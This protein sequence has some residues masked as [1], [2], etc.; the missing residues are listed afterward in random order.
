MA[1]SFI[2]LIGYDILLKYQKSFILT[3]LPFFQEI[4]NLLA[5]LSHPMYQMVYALLLWLLRECP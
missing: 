5:P 4:H 2:P 3:L 1:V